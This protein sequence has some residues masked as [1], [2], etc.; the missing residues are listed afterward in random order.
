MD[1]RTDIDYSDAARCNPA[2]RVVIVPAI[3]VVIVATIRVIT[4]ELLIDKQISR[5]SALV[6]DV[7][8]GNYSNSEASNKV[9]DR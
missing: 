9:I 2:I 8:S 6:D 4:L 7:A 3:R 5:F 1:F